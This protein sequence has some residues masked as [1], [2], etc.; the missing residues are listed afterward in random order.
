VRAG[1]PT[2]PTPPEPGLPSLYNLGAEAGVESVDLT[3]RVAPNA[4]IAEVEAQYIR[5]D[6]H[7][8]TDAVTVRADRLQRI[9]RH[10]PIGGLE[11]NV[12]Y[13]FRCLGVPRILIQI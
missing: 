10:I 13:L 3:W 12:P 2:P 5:E 11:G 9:H 7:W 6:G 1:P 4:R 8:E